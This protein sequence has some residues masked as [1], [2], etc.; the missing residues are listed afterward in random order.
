MNGTDNGEE[1]VNSIGLP[2]SPQDDGGKKREQQRKALRNK[3]NQERDRD[4]RWSRVV[5]G[6][7]G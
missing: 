2:H 6:G 4:G 5:G 1:R 3:R 7:G